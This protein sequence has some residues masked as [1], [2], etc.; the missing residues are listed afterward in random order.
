MPHEGP[1]DG[2]HYWLAPPDLPEGFDGPSTDWRYDMSDEIIYK[3]CRIVALG[4]L[5]VGTLVYV[6]FLITG[7]S[8][9]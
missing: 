1:A 8:R 5:A 2:K 4:S 9:P 7:G 6:L 3:I